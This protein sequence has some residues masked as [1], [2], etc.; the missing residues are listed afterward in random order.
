MHTYSQKY[1]LINDMTWKF[2]DAHR[3]WH[4]DNKEVISKEVISKELRILIKNIREK[5]WD[6]L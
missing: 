5:M 3:S 1:E 2:V 4:S 6:L